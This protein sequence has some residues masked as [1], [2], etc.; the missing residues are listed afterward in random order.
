MQL[1]FLI[2]LYTTRFLSKQTTLYT[3]LIYYK[4][5]IRTNLLLYHPYILQGFYQKKPPSIPPLYTTR[6]LSEKTS[7]YTTLIYYKVSIKINLPLYHPYILQGFNQN[8]R[9]SITIVI[10]HNKPFC[11]LFSESLSPVVQKVFVLCKA[12]FSLL[13]LWTSK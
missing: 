1:Y 3:T 9:P 5:S 4:V 7:F 10:Q 12:P 8:R 11:V 13:M 2:I 6:F